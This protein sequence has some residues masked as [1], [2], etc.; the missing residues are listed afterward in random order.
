MKNFDAINHLKGKS[1]YIDDYPLPEVTLHAFVFDSPIAHGE[2][3]KLNLENALSADGV[4]SILTAN[5]IPNKNQI[6]GIIQDETLLANKEVHFIG[7]PIALILAT[8]ISNA[9]KA[10]K[11]IEIEFEE[12]DIITDPRDAFEKESLIVPPIVFHSGNIDE[13]WN[14]CSI[15]IE[16]TA[17]SGGQEHLYLETQG[18]ISIPIEENKI[19]IISSTQSPTAVQRQASNVLGLP[20]HKIEV[21]V[22]RL[23]G[24]FG[25]KEDQATLW[26]VLTALAAFKLKKPVKLVLSREDDLRITGKRHPYSSDYKIGLSK[27][28]KILAYE[29]TYYQNAGAVADLSTAVLERTLFHA[30]N[31]Y[32]IPNVKATGVSAKTNLPPNTAFRGFGGP[33]GMF[34]IESAIEKAASVLG[35]RASEIQRE[36]LLTDDQYFYY[37]QK[38]SDSQAISSWNSAEDKFKTS[39]LIGEVEK[40]N[41]KNKLLK[42]GLS[43]MPICFGISFTSSF[44][45]QASALVHVYT[46]G[47]VGISTAAVEMGQGVNAKIAIA[48]SNTF[49]ISIDKVKVEST[50]TTRVANTSPTAASSAADMNGNATVLACTAILNRLLRF[51]KDDLKAKENDNIKVIEEVIYINGT[52]TELTWKELINRAYFNRISLSEQSFYSTPEIYFERNINQ[53]SP[54]AYHVYGT[55]ITTATVDIIRGTY[56][57]DSVKI[58]HDFGKSLNTNIDIG[59]V[60]GALVQGIGWMTMEEIRYSKDGKLLANALSTYKI[61]DIY[62][63]PEKVEVEFLDNSKNRFGPFNSK[64]IGEPPLMYGIGAYFAVLDA[65]KNA[66]PNKTFN[67]S[68][69]ITPEKVLLSLYK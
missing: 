44:L 21:D 29:V 32:Y 51:A 8:S 26:G 3:I 66:K 5:D 59:Q 1:L 58:V 35:V 33:Q 47:S 68:A 18:A 67:I 49:S 20:M 37:G 10:A 30:T 46:D 40:F 7:E 23:G 2:I 63:V 11:L 62:S 6:G 28:N 13:A 24:A 65:L 60:E 16:G 15:V 31:S 9:K 12:L 69:P 39:E 61:P 55:A 57:F 48:A 43:F 52:P 54:F 34:V 50:N 53:G 38:V 17:E 64:A 45:N 27:E 42:K 14:E 19:K 4:V 36:N 22:L 56:S 41:S 25:G